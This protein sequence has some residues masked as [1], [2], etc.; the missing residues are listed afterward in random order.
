MRKT[1]RQNCCDSVARVK[2]SRKN[3]PMRRRRTERWTP[4]GW[5]CCLQTAGLAVVKP[6]DPV[7]LTAAKTRS[8]S[9]EQTPVW[10]KERRHE[11]KRRLHLGPVARC[12]NETWCC[13]LTLLLV[14]ACSSVMALQ[15]KAGCAPDITNNQ[16][17]GSDAARRA[18]PESQALGHSS[19]RSR[20]R[21][22]V[23]QLHRLRSI[24]RYGISAVTAV[25]DDMRHL[26]PPVRSRRND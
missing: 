9:V 19:A 20:A 10:A 4:S 15:L 21:R 7:A 24:S 3:P 26:W 25:F 12:A 17:A 14:L 23:Q 6:N 18:F 16:S 2:A 22:N 13:F 1:K 8:R 5:T 11:R